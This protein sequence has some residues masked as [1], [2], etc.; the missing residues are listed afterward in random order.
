[1]KQALVALLFFA[2]F[3]GQA[4]TDRWEPAIAAFEK[5]NKKLMSKPGGIVFYG[6]SSVRR[7]DLKKSFPSK[8]LVNRGFGGSTMADAIKHVD[9]AVLPLKPR[10]ILLYEGDHDIAKGMAPA[11]V[12]HDYKRFVAKVHAALPETKIAF[13][14]IKPSLSRAHLMA[15]VRGANLGIRELTEQDDRLSYIDVDTP[16]LGPNG[17]PIR[18]LFVDDL[19]HL[20]PKGYAIWTRVIGPYL[21]D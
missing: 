18:D 4:E 11:M 13:I 21:E 9:R 7:W 14:S 15:Q 10:L 1:M 8:D 6:S 3:L 17:V 5:S 16:S 20:T 2:P 19:L 12:V